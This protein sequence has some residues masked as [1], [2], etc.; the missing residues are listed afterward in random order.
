MM[1]NGEESR[2]EM[3]KLQLA[4]LIVFAVAA[5]LAAPWLGRLPVALSLEGLLAIH[6]L[7]VGA[8]MAIGAQRRGFPLSNT[9]LREIVALARISH[10]I[11]ARPLN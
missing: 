6:L 9:A 8:L 11:L 5:W 1:A 3:R 2:P 7:R 10:T 4:S